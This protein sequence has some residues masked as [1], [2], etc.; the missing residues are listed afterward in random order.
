MKTRLASL[1]AAAATLAP[2][3]EQRAAHTALF[4]LILQHVCL[5]LAEVLLEKR[6]RTA[7]RHDE[8]PLPI[9]SLR[10]PADGTLV[11]AILDM[12]V[13]AENEHLHGYGK[14][15]WKDSLEARACWRLLEVGERRN[16]ERLMQKLVSLRN[17]G[18]EGHGIAGT[19]DLEAERDVLI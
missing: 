13:I 3:P 6:R 5:V 17:D 14:S 15:I 18:V 9:A 8:V 7:I 2:G 4:R 19:S 1:Q 10:Q 11:A 16:A 12:L